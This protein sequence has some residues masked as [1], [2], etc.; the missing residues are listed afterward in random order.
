MRRGSGELGELRDGYIAWMAPLPARKGEQA[1]VAS[2]HGRVRT[3]ARVGIDCH[4]W[5]QD[6]AITNG[7]AAYGINND[8][9]EPGGVDLYRLRIGRR[10]G[11]QEVLADPP[12]M[13][14][15]AFGQAQYAVDGNNIF[16]PDDPP[17]RQAFGTRGIFQVDPARVRWKRDCSLGR[18]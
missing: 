14:I 17:R 5:L 11:C 1:R 8:D 15:P 10:G 6:V 7:Y 13:L 18:W 4:C 16:Y 2:I 12:H 3:L 9:E